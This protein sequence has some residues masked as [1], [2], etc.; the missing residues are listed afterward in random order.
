MCAH[1]YRLCTLTARGT[2]VHVLK[3][4]SAVLTQPIGETMYQC[5]HQYRLCYP[6]RQG[7]QCTHAHIRIGCATLNARDTH[8]PMLTS[9]PA[10]LP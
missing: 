7:H 8:V 6:N 2:H 1:R 9:V 5:S 10:V 4:E 3:S